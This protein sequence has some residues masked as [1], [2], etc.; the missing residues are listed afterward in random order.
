MQS[1]SGEGTYS[2]QD[3]IRIRLKAYRNGGW[4]RL[5]DVEKA[6]FKASI[7]LAKMRRVIVNPSLV[8]KL[9]SIASKIMQTAAAEVL[10]LG[11]EHADFLLEVYSRN[12]FIKL[13][14]VIKDWLSNRQYLL[15]LGVKQLV[16]K[17]A[18]WV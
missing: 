9:K 6:L 7:W 16:M 11:K 18:G 1:V 8:S 4:R 3:L 13:F 10:Q 12:G 2:Y 5:T 15:W 17:R 14:P